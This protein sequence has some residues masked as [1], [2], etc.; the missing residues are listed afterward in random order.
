[1]ISKILSILVILLFPYSNSYAQFFDGERNGLVLGM[2]MGIVNI[3]GNQTNI[4]NKSQVS[5]TINDYSIKYWNGILG[6]AINNHFMVYNT[7]IA[8]GHRTELSDKEEVLGI[9]KS[10]WGIRYFLKEQENSHY[11]NFGLGTSSWKIGKIPDG[12][13]SNNNLGMIHAEGYAVLIGYGYEFRK[14]I[15]IE[16]TLVYGNVEDKGYSETFDGPEL[17]TYKSEYYYLSI[18]VNI[19][20]F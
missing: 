2:G 12:E 20:I 16:G 6:Y 4:R 19:L 18:T 5:N 9:E 17:N 11:F 1:M 13:N 15:N 3:Y 14:H 7:V 10:I 8:S